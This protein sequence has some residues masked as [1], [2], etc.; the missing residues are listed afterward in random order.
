MARYQPGLRRICGNSWPAAASMPRA[1]ANSVSAAR[2]A[3]SRRACPAA[4][5]RPRRGRKH[6]P[7]TAPTLPDAPE[8]VCASATAAASADSAWP[9]LDDL[10]LGP[11]QENVHE[12]R[13]ERP[14]PLS[15]ASVATRAASTPAC[16]KRHGRHLSTRNSDYSTC[17][18]TGA[19]GRTTPLSDA[20]P[21]PAYGRDSGSPAERAR[22]FLERV[23]F[24]Y[25]SASQSCSSARWRSWAG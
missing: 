3:L 12:P 11:R 4:A 22:T 20:T 16:F 15:S 24:A 17:V 25:E 14:C 2:S 8:R 19:C 1:S 5:R 9:Q 6:R 21:R 13:K 7:D 23:R 18:A 10:V